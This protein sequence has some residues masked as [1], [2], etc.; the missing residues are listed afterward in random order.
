MLG[1]VG[2]DGM[3]V[4]DELDRIG[5]A[6][7]VPPRTLRPACFL[8]L[9]V[10]QGPVLEQTGT[11]IG[12]VTGVQGISWTEL[13]IDGVSNHAGTTP[14]A[15]RR[16]AGL[17]AARICAFVRELAVDLGPAQVA[18][19]GALEFSPGLVN[20]VPERA[21]MTVDLRNIED[22]VLQRAEA[23]LD[24]AARKFTEAE[25]CTLRSRRLARF[26][27]VMFDK[28]LVERLVGIAEQLGFG[29]RRMPS[30]AGHDA[31]MFAPICPTAMIFVPSQDGLS[32]NV[33]EYTAPREIEAGANVLLQMVL[34][35]TDAPAGGA[36]W[37]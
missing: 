26:E 1:V 11:T 20:V 30:G 32:H 10:E 8:E 34:S 7:E 35:A 3:R 29:V 23:R 24:D 2:I 18:T 22:E 6:G 16:D 28:A 36:E 19:V 14:M 17:V 21:S 33:R 25:G 4:S 5:Y 31:Q 37:A 27:P 9:H 15:L 13:T 12:A